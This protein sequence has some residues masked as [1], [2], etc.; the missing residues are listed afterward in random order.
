MTED[1][2][3]TYTG[4]KLYYTDPEPEQVDVQDIAHGLAL[5]PRY[6]GQTEKFLSVAKHSVLVSRELKKQDCS[7]KIQ[8]YGLFHDA[9]EAYMGDIPAPLKKE[10]E[11]FREIEEKIMD[12]IWKALKVEKPRE[13]DWKKIKD[14]DRVL[15]SHEASELVSIDDWVGDV[16][17]SYSLDS[18]SMEEDRERFM[19]R[20]REL[21]N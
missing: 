3:P 16:D 13:K 12:A 8:L 5:N 18:G 21:K 4:K 15:L 9:A 10:L 14:A 6:G 1:F 20:F 7:E 2:I 11:D 17:R 19:E